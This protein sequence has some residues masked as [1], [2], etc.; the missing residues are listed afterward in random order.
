MDKAVLDKLDEHQSET[1]AIGFEQRDIDIY[2]V[3]HKSKSYKEVNPE[4][5]IPC[6]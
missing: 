4:G 3:E 2:S 5:T 6:L 1:G